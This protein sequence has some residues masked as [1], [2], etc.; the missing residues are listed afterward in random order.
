MHLIY[1]T[2]KN[3]QTI[4]RRL[5][6][7]FIYVCHVT[8]RQLGLNASDI[9]QLL[10]YLYKLKQFPM[11]VLHSLCIVVQGTL[12]LGRNNVDGLHEVLV[13][14]DGRI[15]AQSNHARLHGHGLHLCA[16]EVLGAAGQLL[17]VHILQ[18]HLIRSG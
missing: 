6:F 15:P 5:L 8:Q 16:V 1:R 4:R 11:D 7:V 12:L 17:E 2:I 14:D 10:D 3:L 9:F 13:L 18:V